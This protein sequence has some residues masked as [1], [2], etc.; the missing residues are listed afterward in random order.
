[1]CWPKRHL[2]LKDRCVWQNFYI[3][4]TIM[5]PTHCKDYVIALHISQ[6]I[7]FLDKSQQQIQDKNSISYESKR[8]GL[9]S[10]S[11]QIILARTQK[12]IISNSDPFQYS[13]EETDIDI[14]LKELQ[15]II[16]IHLMKIWTL[17]NGISTS[18]DLVEDPLIK[19]ILHRRG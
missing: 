9:M 3:F 8:E 19:M 5:Q 14:R 12:F 13:T 2:F 17:R 10:L 11:S 7:L 18:M 4:N 16:F 6:S 15:I 1:M